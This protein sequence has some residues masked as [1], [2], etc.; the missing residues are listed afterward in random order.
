MQ[1]GLGPEAAQSR[2]L[3]CV[4][5][6]CR[7]LAIL[8]RD[9]RRLCHAAQPGHQQWQSLANLLPETNL[10]DMAVQDM[11]LKS[12]LEKKKYIYIFIREQIVKGCF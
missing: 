3:F 4:L 11:D 7:L 10:F 12:C 9:N 5:A 6:F 2:C 1:T 8:P